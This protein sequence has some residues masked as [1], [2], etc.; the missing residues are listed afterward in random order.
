MNTIA[1]P[2]GAEI[3]IITWRS[4][5]DRNRPPIPSELLASFIVF[6]GISLLA[7]SQPKIASLMGWGIVIATALNVF[8]TLANSQPS[9]TD[10]T[11]GEPTNAKGLTKLA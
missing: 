5:K 7:P 9:A 3:A 8:P 2:W 1:I 6:G 10:Q 11:S 4:V